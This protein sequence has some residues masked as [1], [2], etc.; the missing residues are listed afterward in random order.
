MITKI[1][2][3]IDIDEKHKSMLKEFFDI[4]SFGMFAGKSLTKIE[5]VTMIEKIGSVVKEIE[6]S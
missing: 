4:I 2:E 5:I 6:R 3:K 1:I